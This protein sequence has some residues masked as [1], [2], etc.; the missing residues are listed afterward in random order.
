MTEQAGYLEFI[1]SFNHIHKY[2]KKY[3]DSDDN[4]S[5]SDLLYKAKGHPMIH[6]YLDDLHLFRK[7]RNIIVHQTDDFEQLIAYPSDEVVER[8]K[9]IEQQLVDP[10]TV[11]VFK[12]E[13][14]KFNATDSITEVLKLS[15]EKE[16]LKLPIYENDKFVGLV[17]SRAIAKWLQ[18]H[19]ENN[20]IE[21][22]G[23]VKDLLDYEKKSQYEFV[24]QSMTVYDAWHLFQSSPKKLDALLL[25]ESG[26]QE[27]QIEA[28]ITYDDVLRYI[29]THDQYVFN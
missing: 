9:F 10:S 27:D 21:L 23:S 20:T 15:G 29:Y 22:S 24:A 4:V 11:S 1:E 7:L 6:L 19:I 25:T 3:T 13:V 5:F 17:T 28:V 12:A 2:L 26:R 16:I 18:K 14:V 8:I